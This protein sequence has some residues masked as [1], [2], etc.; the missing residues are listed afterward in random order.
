MG[1][2]YITD[3]THS[4]MF[5]VAPVQSNSK[6]ASLLVV[7]GIPCRAGISVQFRRLIIPSV[8]YFPVQQPDICLSHFL[9]LGAIGMALV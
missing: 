7:T 5:P 9:S 4:R 2:R 8:S 3:S 1:S 6:L